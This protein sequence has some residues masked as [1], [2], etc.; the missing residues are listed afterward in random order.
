MSP[1]RRPHLGTER[2]GVSRSSEHKQEQPWL[3]E[4]EHLF[5]QIQHARFLGLLQRTDVVVHSAKP[6]HNAYGEFLFVRVSQLVETPKVYTFYGLGYHE[7]RER[8][9]VDKWRFFENPHFEA[10]NLPTLAKPDA[11]QLIAEREADIRL[12]ARPVRQSG[13]AQLYEILADLGDEDGALAE[14]EDLGWSSLDDE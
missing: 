13:Q 5:E 11:L 12:H 4:N 2:G 6:D 9:V 7:Y 8:W 1:E 14:L 10:T 3:T